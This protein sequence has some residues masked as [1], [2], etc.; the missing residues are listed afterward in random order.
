MAGKS[1]RQG[2]TLGYSWAPRCTQS[3]GAA[4]KSCGNFH[5]H[6][7]PLPMLDQHVPDAVKFAGLALALSKQ[8]CLRLMQPY[9]RGQHSH[10]GSPARLCACGARNRAAD[11]LKWLAS[12]QSLELT[13]CHCRYRPLRV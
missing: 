2:L 13:L 8:L 5:I 3:D 12:D 11:G 4:A 7:K 9:V 1:V 6:R 10:I